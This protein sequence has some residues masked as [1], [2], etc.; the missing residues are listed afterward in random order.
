MTLLLA[1]SVPVTAQVA[2]HRLSNPDATYEESLSSINGVRELP[3]GRLMLADGLGQALIVVD[4]STGRA[5][6]IGG[7]GGGPQ[8]YRTPDAVF[9]LPGDS[10]LLVDLGN[11]RLTVIGPDLRF[12]ETMPLT[13]GQPG[14]GPGG[15]TVLIP[16]AVDRQGRIYVQAAGGMSPSG[17]PDSTYIVRYDRGTQQLD[18]LV[19]VKLGERTVSRSGAAGNQNVQ[20][21]PVPL[22]P[23][24]GWGVAPDGRIAMVRT[25]QYRVEW[26]E[27][28]GRVVSGPAVDYRPIRIGNDEQTR[29]L[30]NV[31]RDGL[32]VSVSV[33]NGQ[34]QTAFSRG[35]GSD[36]RPDP[37][38]YEWPDVMPAFDANDVAVDPD[39]DVWVGRYTR[40]GQ[41]PQFD[42]F[43]GRGRLEAQV[44]LPEG[45]ELAGFGNGVVY[46]TYY[47]EFDLQYVE[48]YRVTT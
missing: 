35:G 8:E 30:D 29:W 33:N 26:R 2:Q 40:A 38:Q 44:T 11:G 47:D 10:T 17:P 32:R 9:A 28:G 46:L 4:M 19:Q 31:G 37:D 1:W 18:S 39:G 22:S 27:P 6:T 41:P 5:D 48:R 45:R 42:V 24:D 36:D 21:R 43:D 15:L 7:V 13:L 23:Q 20:I 14:A 12:G 34:M 3:D 25:D 16:R